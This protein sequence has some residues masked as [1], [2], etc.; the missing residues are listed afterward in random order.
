M[1]PKGDPEAVVDPELRVYGIQN[2]R[3]ADSSIPPTTI[4]GH[5]QS[6]AYLVGEKLAELLKKEYGI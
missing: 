1:G 2:L 5:T 6:L 3:V 4:A